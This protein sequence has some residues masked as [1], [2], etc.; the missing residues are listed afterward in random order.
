M[1]SFSGV[2]LSLQSWTWVFAQIFL[3][4]KFKAEHLRAA[5]SALAAGSIGYLTGQAK[6][7]HNLFIPCSFT[8]WIFTEVF[9]HLIAEAG[10]DTTTH[11]RA[12]RNPSH[13]GQRIWKAGS[14][15]SL[16]L[17]LE[18]RTRGPGRPSLDQ[19][20]EM[21]HPGLESRKLL[22][23]VFWAVPNFMCLSWNL[24]IAL[25]KGWPQSGSRSSRQS[26]PA[27]LKCQAQDMPGT[28]RAWAGISVHLTDCPS[29]PHM[30]HLYQDTFDDQEASR[31]K[32]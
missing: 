12:L 17:Y 25:G 20:P 11:W 13:R 16:S 14:A 22:W 1:D 32:L 30:H 18:P 31:I 28:C 6:G 2:C 8:C 23:W 19:A 27:F 15:F 10:L 21:S 9:A 4:I 26:L 3:K 7:K 24:D 5:G 29:P